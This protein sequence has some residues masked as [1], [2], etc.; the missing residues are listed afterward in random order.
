MIT[1]FEGINNVITRINSMLKQGSQDLPTKKEQE[2]KQKVYCNICNDTRFIKYE[3]DKGYDMYK[4][5]KCMQ[6]AKIQR[7]WEQSG[8]SM[9]NIDKTFKNFEA[10]NK[11][12]NTMKEMA[13]NYF[14]RFEKIRADRNNSIM[15]CG[16]PGC[17]KTHLSLALA[18]KLLKD[19]SIGVVYMS[20]RDVITSLKQN[21]IDE[22]YYKKTLDKYQKAEV[23]LI[24]DLYKGKTTESDINIMF[25]L[26]N[27][28]YFHG[29]PIIISTEHTVNELLKRDEA[30]GSRLY[31]MSKGY[32]MEIKG[33]HNNYRLR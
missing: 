8:I 9:E 13:L 23:L 7:I 20:Y 1:E 30:V 15:F 11:E 22:D 25:E 17:G 14:M 10:W 29:L 2:Q 12:I 27:Y 26:V 3:D 16:N 5:C 24:D 6:M 28:R 33:M 21:M 31:E 19:N 4:P 18:N 32:V